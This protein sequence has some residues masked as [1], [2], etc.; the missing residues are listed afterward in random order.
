MTSRLVPPHCALLQNLGAT[1]ARLWPGHAPALAV[2]APGRANL[3]GGHVDMHGGPVINVALDRGVWLMAAP[4]ADD[5]S[6]LHAANLDASVVLSH[7]PQSLAART[8]VAG[9]P[10]PDWARYPAAV[11][12]ALHQR[13]LPV[14]GL[15]GVFAG[16]LPIGAGLSSS[17]ALEI[18]LAMAWSALGGWALA[19]VELA[20]L[21]QQAEREY[22]GLGIGIQ[23]QFTALH[24][25]QG[26][27]LWLDCRSLDHEHIPLPPTATVLI[28]DTN[29]RRA[30]T[31]SG[32]GSRARDAHEAA[33]LIQ[34]RDP[35]VRSL[36]D[37][38]PESLEEHRHMLSEAQ[39]RR[40]R[41]VVSEIVR[42]QR[43]AAMLR[44]GDLETF[45]ALMNESYRSAR[46]DYGSSSPALDAMWTAT[47]AQ[48][49]CYGARY[50]GG[51][52]AGAVV[53][54]VTSERVP[55]F[56]A[57]AAT[58]YERLTGREGTFFPVHPARSAE[59]YECP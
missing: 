57:G 29:T 36:R 16:D 11:L 47:T 7:D 27:A 17:A 1:F 19:P 58:A 3:L 42:V 50:S 44:Q 2:R 59:V 35:A 45:G 54:L 55:D 30:L 24:A 49:G 6:T 46:D 32:Y 41:H 26:N 8:D 33:R 9:R 37:V 13:G 23:D 40:A 18:A 28:C 48:P 5:I 56:V 31:G 52:E 15:R 10:L 34:E 39:Y 43:A 4:A 53:A 14:P 51:G 20:T 21:T 22:L 38:T 12:W 25:R